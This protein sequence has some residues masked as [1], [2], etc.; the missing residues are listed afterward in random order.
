LNKKILALGL[1]LL[2]TSVYTGSALMSSVKAAGE[3]QWI[4]SYKIEDA[5]TGQT[6]V[7][8][9]YATGA[10]TTFGPVLPG[11]SLKVTFA[12]DVI[13]SGSGNLQLTTSLRKTLQDKY[14]ELVTQNYTLGNDFNPN[15]QSA[16]FNW[17]K[18][19]FTMIVYGSV[20]STASNEFFLVSLFGPGGDLLDRVS[21]PVVTAEMDQYLTLLAQ[22]QSKLNSLISSGVAQGY[23]ELYTNVLNESRTVATN[24]DVES[25]IALLNGLD[26]SNEPVSST[27]E[28]LFLP[29]VGVLA[30]VAVVFVILFMRVRGKVSYFQL[31][32]E[33]QIKD[34]EG[35]TLRISKI[36]RTASS[37][38]ESVKDR[39]KRLVG[40]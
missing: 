40:M 2:L 28:S 11:S 4:T 17:V 12:I 27:M 20:P 31:I 9:D 26:V 10:N 38:L 33:D 21:V 25:A 14:W 18:G 3:G 6:L 7:S 13:T 32:V 1:L 36:D 30:V 8:V 16:K 22:K 35:L 19:T 24:G 29:I 23:I 37:S 5:T 39:L 34:L 15:Q